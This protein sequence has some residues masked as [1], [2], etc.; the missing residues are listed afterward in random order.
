MH[1]F[2]INLFAVNYTIGIANNKVIK[3]NWTIKQIGK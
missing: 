1:E 3:N 2:F